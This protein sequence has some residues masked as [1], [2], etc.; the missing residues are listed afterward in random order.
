MMH[1]ARSEMRPWPTI[2]LAGILSAAPESISAEPANDPQVAAAPAVESGQKAAAE[3]Y[4][5]HLHTLLAT[6]IVPG[7]R[8]GILHT[9]ASRPPALKVEVMDDDAPYNVGVKIDAGGSITVR[10]SLGYLTTH[11]AAL[12]AVGLSAVLGRP[13]DLRQYLLYQLQVAR[14]N[15]WYRAEGEDPRHAMTFAEYVRLDPEMVRAT[16]ARRDWRGSRARV[17]VESLGWA[18]AYLLIRADARLG[19]T[20]SFSLSEDSRA[21]A[22][23]A[24]ASGWFPVP[25]FA[26]ALQ[27]ADIARGPA[28]AWD[29]LALLC[30]TA[31]LLEGGVAGLHEDST[32]SERVRHDAALQRR[33]AEILSQISALRRD[34]ACVSAEVVA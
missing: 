24:A 34:G 1:P 28:A 10:L 14:A 22:R 13:R 6:W 30:R 25:P 21:A 27:L 23:L 33:V 15:Y 16:F 26:T 12:D 31:L 7:L 3:R 32:W 29:E 19:G 5:A 20:P 17:E 2:A 9:A 4:I 18:I 11:D 8:R